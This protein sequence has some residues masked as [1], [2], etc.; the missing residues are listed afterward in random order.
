[1]KSQN[2]IK[3]RHLDS[4]IE[5]ENKM[6]NQIVNQQKRFGQLRIED[7]K[8]RRIH[9]VKKVNDK[10]VEE[11]ERLRQLKEQEVMQMEM[12]EMELIKKL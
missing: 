2:E 11:E 10:K 5:T 12:L 4:K 9:S 3:K 1:M 8:R 6:K 7:D